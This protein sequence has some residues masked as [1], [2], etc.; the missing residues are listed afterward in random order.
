MFLK[1]YFGSRSLA[2]SQKNDRPTQPSKK[3]PEQ[4][5]DGNGETP[6][7]RFAKLIYTQFKILV[8]ERDRN[9]NLILEKEEVED[10][11][12][13][14]FKLNI[15]EQAQACDRVMNYSNTINY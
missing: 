15:T 4:V 13:S 3:E 7:E 14:L 1:E 12:S 5:F 11:L 8:M 2:A 10:I 6:Q 9:R